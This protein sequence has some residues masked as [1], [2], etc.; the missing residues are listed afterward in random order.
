M[1]RSGAPLYVVRDALGHSS[2]TTTQLYLSRAGAHEAVVKLPVP[3]PLPTPMPVP[4]PPPKPP[5]VPLLA[6]PPT[7]ITSLPKQT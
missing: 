2:V 3:E 5:P 1:G 4:S 6:A 7:P